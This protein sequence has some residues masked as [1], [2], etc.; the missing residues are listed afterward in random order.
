ME[1]GRLGTIN[2]ATNNSFKILLM[3]FAKH[4]TQ[5]DKRQLTESLLYLYLNLNLVLCVGGGWWW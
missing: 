1:G 5:T 3:I 2:S 4:E